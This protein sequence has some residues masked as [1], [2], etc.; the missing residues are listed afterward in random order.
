MS[1]SALGIVIAA[2]SWNETIIPYRG[3]ALTELMRD[4]LGGNAKTL[5]L[6]FVN[7]SPAD[8]NCDETLQALRYAARVKMITNDAN[9][10]AESAELDEL[11]AQIRKLKKMVPAGVDA[12]AALNEMAAA[13]EE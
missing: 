7:I 10:A 9:A 6:M 11:K 1:L 8:Y 12:S 13:G 4:S 2:F 5:D 3:S